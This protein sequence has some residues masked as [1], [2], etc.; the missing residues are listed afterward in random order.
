MTSE[1]INSLPDNLLVEGNILTGRVTINGKFLDPKPS[2]D[3][4]NHSPNG[5]CWGY[6]GSAPSQLAL[7]ILLKYLP[8][9][10]AR[11]LYM[12]FKFDVIAG[13]PQIDISLTLNLREEIRKIID[14]K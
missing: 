8:K 9:N 10:W 13:W 1:Q 7:A 12:Q 3:I 4:I 14:K 11:E 6:S 5:F 2:Q